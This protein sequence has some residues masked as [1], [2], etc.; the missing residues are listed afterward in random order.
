[1]GNFIQV[2]ENCQKF[3][4]D[5]KEV[6]LIDT[7]ICTLFRFCDNRCLIEYISKGKLGN[8]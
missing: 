2:C 3:L 4:F 1:M 7:N 6:Y 8:R 5:G